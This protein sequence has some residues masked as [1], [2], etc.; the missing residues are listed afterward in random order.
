MVGDIGK[1]WQQP[2]SFNGQNYD[3]WA[4]KMKTIMVINYLSEFV[5]NGFNDVTNPTRYATLTNAQKT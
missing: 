2:L 3:P 5:I 4:K 1:I